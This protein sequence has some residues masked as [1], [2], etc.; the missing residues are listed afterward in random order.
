MQPIESEPE[1]KYYFYSGKQ[2]TEDGNFCG[3]LS[4]VYP[5]ED[6]ANVVFGKIF[7]KVKSEIPS[8]NYPHIEK[9]ELIK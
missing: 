7:E 9:F 1:I 5:S 4:G 3:V 6:S 8:G 2:Y